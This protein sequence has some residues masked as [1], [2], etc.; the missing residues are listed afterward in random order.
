M[1]RP[2]HQVWIFSFVLAFALKAAAQDLPP[3]P[4]DGLRDDTRALSPEVRARLA[5][6]IATCRTALDADIWFTA[7]TFLKSGQSIRLQA[8]TLRQ[9][10]SP[11]GRDAILVAYDR[12]SDTHG[13]SLS[14]GIWERY[15]SAE[16][17][18]LI[19]RSMATMAEKNQPLEIRLS[20]MLGQMLQN[21]QTLEKQRHQS[22]LTLSRHHLRLAQT[23]AIGLGGGGLFL[24][25]LGFLSRR[26]DVQAAW[27]SYFPSAH[28]GIRFGAPHGGGVIVEKSP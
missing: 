23:F 16:I 4:A 1:K 27:Q 12:S 24:A 7:G 25:L 6:D 9:H 18:T 3:A 20:R 13:L 2:L 21:L 26:Q 28:V 10:W 17:T 19:Q 15:P 5:Q 11:G 22:A 14:P 8:R